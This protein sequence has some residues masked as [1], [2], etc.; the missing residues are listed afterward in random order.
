MPVATARHV[1]FAP[2]ETISAQGEAG[3]FFVDTATGA[4]E[5]WVGPGGAPAGA[6]AAYASPTTIPSKRVV[7]QA[8]SITMLDRDGRVLWTKAPVEH[9]ARADRVP[10]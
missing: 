6:T 1:K 4:T 9:L 3:I 2:G 7:T 10:R 5:G 8:S